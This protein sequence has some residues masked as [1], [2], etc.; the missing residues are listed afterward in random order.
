[1]VDVL[2]V[3]RD[4]YYKIKEFGYKKN[5]DSMCQVLT[6]LKQKQIKPNVDD[7]YGKDR[8][9]P[10]VPI[11]VADTTDALLERI[12]EKVVPMLRPKP[13]AADPAPSHPRSTETPKP[14][15]KAELQKIFARLQ[16]IEA[17]QT[18]GK[19]STELQQIKNELDETRKKL[20]KCNKEYNECASNK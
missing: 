2:G 5:K 10:S 11:P 14:D 15:V 20:E 3:G 18:A 7:P 12:A 1:M 4:P 16:E 19:A 13:T 17:Q 8:V 6:W 9:E